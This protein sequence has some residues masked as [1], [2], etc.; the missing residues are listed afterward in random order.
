VITGPIPKGSHRLHF[1]FDADAWVEVRDANGKVIFSRLNPAG[2]AQDVQ[3]EAPLQVVIGN[4]PKVHLSVDGKAMELG[5][6]TSSNVA[7]L[8]LP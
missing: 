6:R 7:R 5:A 8:S 3:G 1:A 2:S 4:A